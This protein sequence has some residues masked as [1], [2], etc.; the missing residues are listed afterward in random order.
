MA[1]IFD[2]TNKLVIV[3]APDTDVTIQELVDEIRDWQDELVNMETDN[4]CVA[5]GKED[6]AGGVQ[7]GITLELIN[8]WRLQ[9]EDRVSPPW[10][11]CT[12]GGGNL[13]ATNVYNNEP[14][15]PSAYVNTVI[16]QSSSATLLSASGATLG[17]SDI[18]TIVDEVWDEAI[19]EHLIGGS[20]GEALDLAASGSSLT[21]DG[22][23]DSVWDEASADHLTP[24][25]VGEAQDLAASGSSLT[26]DGIADSVWDEPAAD[27]LTPDSMGES[28][29]LAAS[30]S[31]LTYDGVADAVWDEPLSGH[32][33]LGT[34]GEELAAM[35]DQ[36]ENKLVINEATS[37]LWLYDDAGT[38]VVKVWPITDK[39]GLGVVLTGQGPANRDTRTL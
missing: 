6:L 14:V 27:H 26:Y 29:D 10:D 12:V 19:A 34:A 24:G 20:I 4:I 38:S 22:I 31:S 8:D 7:V 13:V 2:K 17:P 36:L 9:F 1:I 3:E 16:A 5:T 39:D 11:I 15:Y 23:A 35:L 28:Q 18:P 33:T 32:S 25:T 21:Y 30:G 37:E